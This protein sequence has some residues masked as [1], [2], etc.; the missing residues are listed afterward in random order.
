MTKYR[1]SKSAGRY[2]RNLTPYEI[3]KCKRDTLVFDGV[4]CVNNALDFLIK[5]KGEERTVNKKIVEYNLQLHAYNGS[6]F[7]IW[8]I[9][10]NFPCDKHI[11]DNV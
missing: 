9:L 2:D 11:F 8:I 10:N 3:E 7:D 5:L 1:L 4:F 6:G